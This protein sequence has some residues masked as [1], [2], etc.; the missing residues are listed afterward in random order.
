[1]FNSAGG[2]NSDQF[3]GSGF[4]V[5]PAETYSPD[6]PYIL[7]LRDSDDVFLR[8]IEGW[9]KGTWAEKVN[10]P[11]S[12]K[13]TIPLDGTLAQT[14]DLV[15][16][17]R[18]WLYDARLRLMRRFVILKTK[19]NANNG[20]MAV[21]CVGLMYLLKQEFVGASTVTGAAPT[22]MGFLVTLLG[23]QL[24]ASPIGLGYVAPKYAKATIVTGAHSDQTI[25]TALMVLWK[26]FGGVMGIDPQGRFFWLDD[27]PGNPRFVMTLNDD[28]ETFEEIVNADTVVNRVYA[29]GIVHFDGTATHARQTLTIGYIEDT[30]SQA[31]YGIRAKRINLNIEDRAELT[32]AATR[33]LQQFKD[34]QITR[35]VSAID[36]ARV[37]LDPA[38][39]I[40]PHEEFIFAGG[41]V[42]IKP[43]SNVPN[44]TAFATMILSV[45]RSLDDFVSVKFTV[46]EGPQPGINGRRILESDTEFFDILAEEFDETEDYTEILFNEDNLLWAAFD[47][48]DLGVNVSTTGS[49]IA[50]VDT[51]SALGSETTKFAPVDHVHEGLPPLVF[52]ASWTEKSDLGNPEKVSFGYLDDSAGTDEGL[53]FYPPTGSTNGDW[54]PLPS[55]N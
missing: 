8:K 48:F 13:F 40:V 39:P 16:P 11:G 28:I 5:E 54:I 45:T 2:Y 9:Y 19:A 10:D 17:N 50:A 35:N 34:P 30:D 53:W 22:M 21:E 42:K 3:N 49:E 36:L 47:A 33:I 52:D 12:L 27:N 20:T 1:V 51:T 7:Q 4:A 25:F 41:K 15:Y 46:G 6:Q 43:P 14:G 32:L 24:N 26:Q 31:L 55:Y 44:Q 23:N 38:N 18:I 29:K 37:Q